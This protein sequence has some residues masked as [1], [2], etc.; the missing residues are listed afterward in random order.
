VGRAGFW[1]IGGYTIS[2]RKDGRWY[3]DEEVIPNERISRLFSRH[4]CADG[5]GGWVIDVGIDRAPVV[6]EDAPLVVRS[7][8]GDPI[9]GFTVTTSDDVSSALDPTTLEIGDDDALYCTVDRG[10]RG[11]MKAR[12]LRPAYYALAQHID[13]QGEL[14]VLHCRGREF[15]VEHHHAV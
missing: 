8:D 15:P 9:D 14:P 3:A 11:R 1:P 5:K 12:F 2:F 13:F 7:I 10:K 6:V 4:L